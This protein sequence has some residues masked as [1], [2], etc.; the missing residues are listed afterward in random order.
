M[1][2]LQLMPVLCSLLSFYYFVTFS[3][4]FAMNQNSLEYHAMLPIKVTIFEKE[5]SRVSCSH[6]TYRAFLQCSK[7][8]QMVILLSQ[9]STTN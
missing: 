4:I 9:A 1:I 7:Q 3:K 2:N 8:K 6:A 5:V